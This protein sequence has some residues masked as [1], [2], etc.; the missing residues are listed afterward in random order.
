MD[1]IEDL[2]TIYSVPVVGKTLYNRIG[3]GKK[4]MDKY[5]DQE[6]TFDRLLQH[7]GI[8][9]KPTKSNKIGKK[10]LGKSPE[11]KIK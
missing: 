4:N 6:P 11:K 1:A 3:R 9:D 2:R 5:A 7:L 8:E 10:P